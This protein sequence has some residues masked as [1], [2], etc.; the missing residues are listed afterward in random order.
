LVLAIALNGTPSVWHNYCGSSCK[1]L[2][3]AGR[4][5]NNKHGSAGRGA[6]NQSNQR[7]TD[8][9]TGPAAN[10]DKRSANVSTFNLNVDEVPYV[11]EAEPYRFNDEE[12]YNIRVNG[13]VAHVY[14]WD[15]QI[16]RF[17][18]LDDASEIPDTL[19]EAISRKLESG[20]I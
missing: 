3:M 5:D 20:R 19:D 4:G 17:R 2:V 6:S 13:G 9:G 7:F 16:R 15:A 8:Q 1:H 11:V 14:A 18:S 12:R 10:N